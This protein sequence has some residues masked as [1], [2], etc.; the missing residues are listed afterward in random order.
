MNGLWDLRKQLYGN[1]YRPVSI[2]TFPELLKY[3]LNPGWTELARCDPPIPAVSAPPDAWH[4]STGVLADGLQIVDIDLDKPDHC[5]DV[6]QYCLDHLGDAPIRFRP[7]A[8]R[9]ALLY[10]AAEGSP[11]KAKAW[12]RNPDRTGE[13]VEVLGHGNQLHAYGYHPS[14]VEI[15]WMDDR[16]PHNVSRDDLIAVDLPQVHNLLDYTRQ[17]LGV[18][19]TV[20][21]R[22]VAP[23]ATLSAG[24][25]GTPQRWHD[26]DILDVLGSIP[27]T[28]VDYDWWLRIC[29]ATFVASH[30]TAYDVF[31][32]WSALNVTHDEQMCRNTW[33]ALYRNPPNRITG[34]TLLRY[35]RDANGGSYI[36][37]SRR[38]VRLPF[39]TER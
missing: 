17:L 12:K 18:Q 21:T 27:N 1:G 11:G 4:Q 25:V 16:G 32:A 7:N 10:R 24:Y 5:L 38:L 37:P 31:S 29:M 39:L 19:E 36:K 20:I 3:P 30:G 8:C 34:S 28:T 22:S 2:Q 6:A 23:P 14:G 15:E 13:G 33:A 9:V 26:A 35:A